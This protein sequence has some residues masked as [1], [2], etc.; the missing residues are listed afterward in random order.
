MNER[1]T[2]IV[3]VQGEK[4]TLD[5]LHRPLAGQDLLTIKLPVG[6]QN[7]PGIHRAALCVVATVEVIADLMRGEGAVGQVAVEDMVEDVDGIA[8]LDMELFG[9]QQVVDDSALLQGPGVFA[10]TPVV[11]GPT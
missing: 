11:E 5:S 10:S 9:R 2:A 1:K 6:L 3:H 8:G 7:A 4:G